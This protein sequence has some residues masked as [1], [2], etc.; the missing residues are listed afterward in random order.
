MMCAWNGAMAQEASVSNADGTMNFG[1]LTEA[2]E[3]ANGSTKECVVTLLQDADIADATMQVTATMTLDLNGCELYGYATTMVE[4]LNGG[5]MTLSDSKGSGTILMESDAD[6]TAPLTVTNGTLTITGGEIRNIPYNGAA[7]TKNAGVKVNASGTLNVT[8]GSI[9]VECKT[10]SYAVYINGGTANISGGELYAK[11]Q[12]YGAAL[13]VPS[14]KMVTVSGG[15]LNYDS[16]LGETFD[17]SSSVAATKMQLSGGSYRHEGNLKKYCAG[18]KFVS[19]KDGLYVI[20]DE[21]FTTRK[22]HNVTKGVYYDDLTVALSEAQPGDMVSVVNDCT[23]SADATVKAGVTLLVPFDMLNTC[24]KDRPE[25]T[26]HHQEE[27]VYRTLTIAPGVT[28][29]VLGEMSVSSRLSGAEG[30]QFTGAGSCYG[31]HAAVMMGEGS[32]IDVKDAAALYCWGY[33]Y[34]D[35]KVEMQGGSTLYEAFQIT[36]WHGGDISSTIIDTTFPYNQ[37]YVQNVEV[38]VRFMP[39]ARNMVATNL[40]FGMSAGTP[41]KTLHRV[42]DSPMVSTSNKSLFITGANTVVDRVYDPQTDRIRYTFDGDMTLGCVTMDQFDS[43]GS[44]L[45]LPNNMSIV[46]KTGNMTVKKKYV[47]SAGAEITICPDA[48]MMVDGDARLYVFDKDEWDCF[49]AKGYVLPLEYTMANGHNNRAVRWGSNTKGNDAASY[50]KVS[51]ARLDI[52]GMLVCAGQLLSSKGGAQ[53]VCSKEQTGSIGV[54]KKL[55]GG[56]VSFSAEQQ[57]DEIMM[58]MN[59]TTTLKAVAM[60]P[61]QL[62][63]ADATSY[64]TDGKAYNTFVYDNKKWWLRGDANGDRKVSVADAN[65]VLNAIKGNAPAAFSPAAAD[66]NGDGKINMNDANGIVNEYVK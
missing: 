5:R 28:L 53:V 54:T 22:I 23:L 42:D 13:Y 34:G 32:L 46:Q 44:I 39:G 63:N 43:N 52:Q 15:A 24:Y 57:N 17:I 21:P 12:R 38:P 59:N 62:R 56:F 6:A 64:P 33:I 3:A 50:A 61:L 51:D 7:T 19:V 29:T 20:G 66:I 27:Y 48:S 18:D 14:A 9:K 36:D 26:F 16:Q 60:E 41:D 58:C 65:A 49:A 10:Y 31:P 2:V 25:A 4:I 35:G 30:G 55:Y 37:Y 8:G 11:C 1:T 40:F 45:A 47:L